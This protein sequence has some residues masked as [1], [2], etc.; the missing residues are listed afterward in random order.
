MGLVTDFAIS[1]RK[2]SPQEPV[3]GRSL[4]EKALQPLTAPVRPREIV[5]ELI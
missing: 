3:S 4:T 2:D 5:K 1:Q